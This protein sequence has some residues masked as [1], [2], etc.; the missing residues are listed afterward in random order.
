[1]VK[2][3]HTFAI[4]IAGLVTAAGTLGCGSAP[5]DD[6]AHSEEGGEPTASAPAI[7]EPSPEPQSNMC[8]YA[9]CKDPYGIGWEYVGD[10]GWGNCT[11]AANGTVPATENH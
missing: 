9:D 4:L 3:R 8:C 2:L 1:M 10:P 11:N 7:E 6:A 5:E